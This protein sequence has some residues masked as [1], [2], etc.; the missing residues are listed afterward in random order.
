MKRFVFIQLLCL[1]TLVCLGQNNSF[2]ENQQLEFRSKMG[3]LIAHRASMAHLPQSHFFSGEITYSFQKKGEKY[4]EYVYNYPSFGLSVLT[5]QNK[6]NSVLGQGYGLAAFAKLPLNTNQKWSAN[7]RIAHGLGFLTER[8]DQIE[9]PKNIAI[10]SKLNLLIVLGLDIEY[11]W[12]KGNLNFGIDFT[13]F[14]N[15]GIIKPNLGLNIPSLCIGYG[16]PVKK[17]EKLTPEFEVLDKTL[18]WSTIG[19]F[20]LNQNYLIDTKLY[21]VFGL[22]LN[23]SKYINHKAGV[24]NGID[25][26]FNEAN[27]NFVDLPKDQSFFDVLKIGLFSSYDFRMNKLT[28]LI[29]MGA[30][31]WNKYNPNGV[32]YHRIGARLQLNKSLFLNSV[33]KTHWAKAD[34]F[35][36]G[37][38]YI[39][40][41]KK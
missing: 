31:V 26:M 2:F 12:E 17:T 11:K 8:F 18:K 5:V 13:H 29:G 21:P 3:F 7:I 22:S 28:I 10:G 36:F 33:V 4:W 23:A 15:S 41:R 14:S 1:H 16:F 37:V 38:G 24:T 34:Y 19:V 30:Y 6:N 9:N 39:F 27:R 40:N 32:F 25:F 20:S 35:E